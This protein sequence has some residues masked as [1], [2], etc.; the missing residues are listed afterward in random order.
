MLSMEA[1]L[2]PEQCVKV[3]ELLYEGL[4]HTYTDVG[5][6][7]LHSNQLLRA[8]SD[9]MC[10]TVLFC[11]FISVLQLFSTTERLT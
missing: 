3:V 1:V 5:A 4:S 9:S 6:V 8:A 2:N 10:V 7:L 11:S